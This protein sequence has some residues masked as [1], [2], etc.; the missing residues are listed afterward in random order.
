M[1][2]SPTT[3]VT[4]VNLSCHALINCVCNW[5]WNKLSSLIHKGVAPSII[6]HGIPSN[7]SPLLCHLLKLAYESPSRAAPVYPWP[8][9][10]PSRAGAAFACLISVSPRKLNRV[11]H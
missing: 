8:S 1:S 7:S 10:F 9:N 6:D 3:N 2:L 5:C 4:K 11:S